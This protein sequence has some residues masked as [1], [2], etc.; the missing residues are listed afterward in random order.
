MTNKKE[1]VLKHTLVFYTDG[2]SQ[3][4]PGYAGYGIFGYSL[5]PSKK[6][7]SITWPAKTKYQFTTKGIKLK[8]ENKDEPMEVLSIYEHI[9]SF[10]GDYHTNNQAEMSAVLKA[11][12]L[13]LEKFEPAIIGKIVVITDSRYVIEG[14]TN[15]MNQ[16]VVNDWKTSKG[17]DVV[18]KEIWLLLEEKKRF[19]EEHGVTLE[20]LWVKGHDEEVGNSIVD[21]Y[22]VAGTDHGRDAGELDLQEDEFIP[23]LFSKE[24]TITEFKKELDN[25]HIIFSYKN[26]VF[27]SHSTNDSDIIMVSVPKKEIEV[28]KRDLNSSYGVIYNDVPDSINNLK[29][30][31]RLHEKSYNV[32]C[33]INTDAIKANKIV[34]RL[35]NF[36]GFNNLI[37]VSVTNGVPKI[38]ILNEKDLLVEPYNYKYPF[39]LEM[40]DTFGVLEDTVAIMDHLKEENYLIDISRYFIDDKREFVLT[41]K[42]KMIDITKDLESLKGILVSRPLLVIGKDTPPFDVLKS[43]G[44]NIE[45]VWLYPEMSACGNLATFVVVVEYMTLKGTCYLGQTNLLGKFLVRSTYKK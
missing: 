44:N 30:I 25:K 38:R 36:I 35:S 11:F 21:L 16:W 27:G 31:Y 19:F 28:G 20:L 18:N 8:A 17:T 3:P 1:E 24:T 43:I 22:A 13:A 32:P 10:F 23:T 42:D 29:H 37:S 7:K 33:K 26:A 40:N 14:F 6:P 41:Y 9:H 45:K 5:K 12:N 4:N 15:H 39:L 34:S 2:S